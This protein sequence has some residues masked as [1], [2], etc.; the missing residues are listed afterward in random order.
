MHKKVATIILNRN[1]PKVTN[2]LFNNLKK[3]NNKI[4]DFFIIEA[5]SLKNNLS[6]NYTWH[7]NWKSAKK[8]GLRFARGMNYALSNLYK[9]KKFNNYEAFFLITNDTTFENYR[10]IEKLFNILH[11]NEKLAILSPCS[12]NWGEY[13]LLKKEK[14][15]FF[16]YIHNNALMIKKKFID[17]V[18]NLKSPGYLNFLFDG[19]NFRGYGLESEL[20][21]KAYSNDWSAAITSSVLSEENESYLINNYED[22]KTDSYDQNLKLYL[23]EGRLWMKNKYGFSNK[24]AFQ[25]YVKSFYDKFFENN[26]EHRKYKL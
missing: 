15:K 9:E 12:K 18:L 20:I 14:T 7:A 22:I 1:L 19:K 25:M 16:W 23:K 11:N 21:A 13:K 5:G 3:N 17:E 6:Q 2:L 10:I 8:N 24:W 26:P 4:S